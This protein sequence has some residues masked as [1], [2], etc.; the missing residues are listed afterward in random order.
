MDRSPSRYAERIFDAVDAAAE[1]GFWPAKLS[2]RF[3]TCWA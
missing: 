1:R 3:T 2:D